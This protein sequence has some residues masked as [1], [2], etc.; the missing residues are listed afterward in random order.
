MALNAITFDLVRKFVAVNL[1]E[2]VP[3]EEAGVPAERVDAGNTLT[4]RVFHARV[5]EMS[6]YV[7]APQILANHQGP[8]FGKVWG[9][10]AHCATAPD[11]E[12]VHVYEELGQVVMQLLMR[13]RQQQ[14][15]R[16]GAV[17]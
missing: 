2:P 7:F 9:I 17:D 4:A 12:L 14:P 13:S 15:L 3:L 1:A 16:Y 5:Q 11:A 6:A 8:D 10:E